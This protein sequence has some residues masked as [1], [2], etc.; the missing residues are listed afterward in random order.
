MEASGKGYT[1]VARLLLEKGAEPDIE[2]HVS[3]W[4]ALYK[5]NHDSL[6][7]TD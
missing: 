1:Q 5:H 2:N 6:I 3:W 7:T 4:A